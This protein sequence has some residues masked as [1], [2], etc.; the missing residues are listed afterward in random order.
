MPHLQYAEALMSTNPE[1]PLPSSDMSHHVDDTGKPA[2]A[3]RFKQVGKFHLPGL[4][5]ACDEM[6]WHHIGLDGNPV[7]TRRFEQVWGFYCVRAAA[8]DDGRWI[9]IKPDGTS[10]YPQCFTWVGNFQEGACVVHSDA[11]YMHIDEEGVPLYPE[12]YAYVGDYRDGIAVAW[13]SA[14]RNCQHIL[15]SGRKLH[16]HEYCYLGVFHKGF[17]KAKD[18]L[19]W[20]HINMSGQPAYSHRFKSIEDF[21]NGIALAETFGG[22]FVRINVNGETIERLA[23]SE[24]RGGWKIVLTGNIGA[25]K[26]TLRHALAKATGWTSFGIDDARRIASDGTPRGEALGWAEFLERVQAPRDMIL[27]YSGCGPNSHLVNESLRLS[28]CRVLKVALEHTVSSCAQR[29]ADRT[30]ATPYPFRQVPDTAML[31]RVQR[32][33]AAEWLKHTHFHLSGGVNPET[34]AQAILQEIRLGI[35]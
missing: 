25:G 31:D 10:A 11:G 27:E 8:L 15:K 22:D 21:Y 3:R 17:A 4:A 23:S 26:T 29:I 30:W 34:N 13:S 5:P 19:G 20:T 18:A 32:D 9:H 14:S 28:G 24:A 2:Y 7:Y 12:R 33:L 1:Y 16:G 6:G 35:H